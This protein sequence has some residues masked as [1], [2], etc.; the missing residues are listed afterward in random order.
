MLQSSLHAQCILCG[1]GHPQGC[2]LVFTTCADGRVEAVFPCDRRYQGYAGYLHGGVIAALLDSAMTN[3]LFAHGRVA[4]TGELAVR[5]LKPVMVDRPAVVSA[6]MD[7]ALAPLFKMRGELR[8]N[9]VIVAR[10]TAKFM[11]VREQA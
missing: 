10:A 5:F 3:C 1:A 9:G 11:E 6:R 2:R 4:L 7:E 8:Q